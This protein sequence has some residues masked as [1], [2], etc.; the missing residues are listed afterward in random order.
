MDSDHRINEVVSNS[1]PGYACYSHDARRNRNLNN[2]ADRGSCE[3][4]TASAE[5]ML[6]LS[7]G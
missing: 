6:F 3:A 1:P 7:C 2:G 5:A 4:A